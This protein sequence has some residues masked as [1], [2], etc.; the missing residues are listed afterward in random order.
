MLNGLSVVRIVILLF[1]VVSII[2]PPDP[3]PLLQPHYKA[4]I[5]PTDRSAPVL[6]IGTLASRFSPLVLLPCHQGT[7]SCSSTQKP[8]SGSRPLYAGRRLP[9][10]QAPDRLIP[11]E[12]HAS[13]FDD[14]CFL[15]TRHQ[16]V[17]FRSSPGRTP[18]RDH[19][20]SFP[21][22]LTTTAFD[23]GR[24]EWF[25]TRSCKPIPGGP[26]PS[27]TQL[28]DTCLSHAPSFLR[29]SAAHYSRGNRTCDLGSRRVGHRPC[30]R[31][32]SFC[33]DV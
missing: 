32:L 23:R 26:P 31:R 5:A 7:G 21:P 3:I 30:N 13:G 24:L 6:C 19:A 8:V 12:L 20:P 9:S 2:R 10:H 18:A 11:V 15:T 29:V 33:P 25:E 16:W 1:P 28:Y 14:T 4:F 22:T 27:S 17:C